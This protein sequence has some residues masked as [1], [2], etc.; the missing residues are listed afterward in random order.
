MFDRNTILSLLT[1]LLGTLVVW[2][3][4]GL[5]QT[6]IDD[7]DIF[8]V[9]AR[10]FAEGHGFVYNVGG[11]RVEG[12]TSMLWTLVGSGWYSIFQSLE[13]P[14]LMLNV[15]LGTVVVSA[16]LERTENRNTYLLM[17]VGAPAWFVWCQ[18]SLMESGLWCLL[19]TL[20]GLAVVEKRNGAVAALIPFLVITRPEAMAWGIWVVLLTFVFADRGARLKSTFPILGSFLL[21]L[22]ALIG[23]RLWY[24]GWPVP[25]TYFAKVTPDFWENIRN[26]LNYLLGYPM[27]SFSVIFVLTLFFLVPVFR[28]QANPVSIKLACF[29]LP[30][31]GIPVLVGGDHFGSFRFYQPLWPLLCLIAA[32]E[33]ALSRQHL[34]LGKNILP[35]LALASWLFFPITGNIKHEFRIA[36][37]GRANGAALTQLFQDMETWPTVGVITA[38]GNKLGYDG[39][40]YDL[41]GLNST[42]MAHA[43]G[44]AANFKNH[45]GFNRA[46]FYDWQPDIVL[47]GD[48]EKFDVLVL[49]GLH[50]EAR[51]LTLYEK[52]TL[53]RNGAEIKAWFRNDF[54][55]NLPGEMP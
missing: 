35:I 15:L 23:F 26:G 54:L 30:G 18:V 10:N 29:I 5:P 7:A 12:F 42:E 51:F 39:P 45:T 33:W 38:G 11:E 17:L 27:S 34:R 14:L 53:H 4:M 3:M 36:K 20:L 1:V 44:D 52:C 22:G 31:L 50:N 6:G 16:C 46:V 28:K 47:C 48:S 37:E 40:M 21:S 19:I 43:P 24:F 2:I 55:L 49:N 32:N 25:N 41:M 8:F 9:Y 13:L